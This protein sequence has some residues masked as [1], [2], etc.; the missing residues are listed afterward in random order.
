MENHINTY[1]NI[2]KDRKTLTKA[3]IWDQ[4]QYLLKNGQDTDANR[5]D[6]VMA[7]L[8]NY[9]QPKVSK[10]KTIEQWISMAVPKNDFRRYLNYIFIDNHIVGTDGHRIHLYS[11]RKGHKPGWY[12]RQIVKVKD[13]GLKYVDYQR[14]I[15][16]GANEKAHI[17]T[18]QELLNGERLI[19]SGTEAIKVIDGYLNSKYLK[20]AL[21]LCNND[22]EISVGFTN[23]I[24]LI[25][26]TPTGSLKNTMSVVMPMRAD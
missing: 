15:E 1:A 8:Y 6:D 4:V 20:D 21:S 23:E 26:F 7:D 19:I 12:D 25:R 17:L 10:P 5:F 3:R 9:F 22:D 18:A 2:A 11:G 24:S 14:F 16:K 13:P